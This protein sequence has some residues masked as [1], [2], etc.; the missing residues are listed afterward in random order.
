MNICESRPSESKKRRGGLEASPEDFEI[1]IEGQ[2]YDDQGTKNS[3][4]NDTRYRRYNEHLV[5]FLRDPNAVFEKRE[6]WWEGKKRSPAEER[7]AQ[8]QAPEQKAARSDS[9]PIGSSTAPNRKIEIR[10]P[11][12]K[13]AKGSSR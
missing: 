10:L 3:A 6:P 1:L 12:K 11:T 5:P 13:K 2:A 7:R 4:K 9:L 8:A